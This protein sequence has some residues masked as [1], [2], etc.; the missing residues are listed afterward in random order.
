ASPPGYRVPSVT[1][2][3]DGGGPRR[4]RGSG[5]PGRLEGGQHGARWGC[6]DVDAAEAQ[7]TQ[8]GGLAGEQ[9]GGGDL[10]IAEHRRGDVELGLGEPAVPDA[11]AAQVEQHSAWA[12]GHRVQRPVEPGLTV[13]EVGAEQV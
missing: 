8:D 9:T 3:A 2:C 7:P 1:G 4:W 12:G 10:E 11:A 5:L 13:A 6:R